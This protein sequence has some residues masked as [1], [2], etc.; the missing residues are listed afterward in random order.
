VKKPH[1]RRVRARAAVP[2]VFPPVEW[3][4][5]LL[6]D[7]GVIN[8]TTLTDALDLATKEVYV[9]STGRPCTLT[10]RPPGALALLI[11]ATS[12]LVGPALRRRV[13][14]D[15]RPSGRDDWRLRVRSTCTR[16][17]SAGRES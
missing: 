11:H 16:R 13:A 5:R 17:T 2:G 3:G 9:L 12:L 15:R 10:E 4:D 6:I 14:R 8:N 1:E 7:G